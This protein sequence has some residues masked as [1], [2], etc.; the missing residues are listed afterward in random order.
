MANVFDS[1]ETNT[2]P[3]TPR[4]QILVPPGR[5]TVGAPVAATESSKHLISVVNPEGSLWRVVYKEGGTVPLPLQGLFTSKVFAEQA[6]ESFLIG[7][8]RKQGNSQ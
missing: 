4:K 2:A 1:K 8:N 6:I 5:T 3:V 7:A